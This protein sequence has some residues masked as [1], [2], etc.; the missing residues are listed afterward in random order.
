MAWRANRPGEARALLDR[1]HAA[2]EELADPVAAARVASRLADCDFIDGHPPQ[3]VARLEP[4]LAALEAAGAPPDI[5]HVAAQLGRYLVFSGGEERAMPYL[6][7]ALTLAEALDQP[8]TLAEAM[9][10]K[11]LVLTNI[12][13]RPREGTILV[14]GALALALEND[15]HSAALR[16]YNNLGA[17]LWVLGK[18]RAAVANAEPALELARR[19][20]DRQWESVFLGSPASFLMM[21][22]RWDE[23]LA[24]A[25]EAEALAPNE[26]V[27]GLVLQMA[28]IHV[29]R[30][31]LDAARRLLAA[32]ESAASSENASWAA[33]YALTEAQLHAAEGRHAEALEA[34][35]RGLALR[36]YSAGSQ[37]LIRFVAL[38]TVADFAGDEKLREL[39]DMIDELEPGEQGSY[40]RAQ[41][42]RFR[43]R[44]PEHDAEAELAAAERLF[45]EAEM[46]FYV[47][48]T[49]LERARTLPEAEARPLLEQARKTFE[50]LG[51]RPWLERVDS[52]AAAA[53]VPA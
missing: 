12:R 30:G 11:G 10:S 6:E 22:G 32:S 49:R 44:L 2:Y 34:V 27:R 20:G 13:H 4:A 16:A 9:N 19:V 48:V 26:F 42:A 29:H 14:E 41:K 43:A 28:P 15:L 23:A 37:G 39:L 40:M 47:A 38:D 18:F 35:D 36:A 24:L 52:A 53:G 46:P 21:L 7:R 51:A 31:D 1:A 25:A 5:A 50:H 3:A 33:V 8:E 17:F 45:E